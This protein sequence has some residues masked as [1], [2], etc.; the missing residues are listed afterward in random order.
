MRFNKNA[1]GGEV[2]SFLLEI[3]FASR[4][5]AIYP[6]ADQEVLT[7]PFDVGVGRALATDYFTVNRRPDI[8]SFAIDPF[9][10]DNDRI[11]S[12]LIYIRL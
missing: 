7:C 5:K 1:S 12:D 11:V 6:N 9:G 10:I 3:P 8:R 4:P 2:G